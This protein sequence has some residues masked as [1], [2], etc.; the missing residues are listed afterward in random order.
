MLFVSDPVIFLPPDAGANL[1]FFSGWR[2]LGNAVNSREF[3]IFIEKPGSYTFLL[4]MP[5]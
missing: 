4:I 2:E 1:L 3:V 5:L